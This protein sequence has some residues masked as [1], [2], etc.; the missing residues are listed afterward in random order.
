MARKAAQV[1]AAYLRRSRVPL[2]GRVGA[3][4]RSL[5]FCLHTARWSGTMRSLARPASKWLMRE[6]TDDANLLFTCRQGR[7][8][9]ERLGPQPRS[10]QRARATWPLPLA[11]SVSAR[12]RKVR[13]RSL[14]D[15]LDQL[16]IPARWPAS[17]RPKWLC[18]LAARSTANS[19]MISCPLAPICCIAFRAHF[20]HAPQRD[21][22]SRALQVAVAQRASREA[23]CVCAYVCV[24]VSFNWWQVRSS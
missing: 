13:I 5:G 11:A 17:M 16:K 22:C 6:L 9:G 10:G 15:T 14:V 7:F 19:P 23:H 4:A 18:W 3:R 12:L 24:L 20:R 21:F 8:S 1:L 2:R